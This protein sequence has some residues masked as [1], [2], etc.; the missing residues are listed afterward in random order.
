ME[1]TIPLSQGNGVSLLFSVRRLRGWEETGGGDINPDQGRLL[2]S[3]TELGALQTLTT[4]LPY[5]GAMGAGPH[6]AF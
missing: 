6:F 5:W 3:G 2:L 1:A 4:Q